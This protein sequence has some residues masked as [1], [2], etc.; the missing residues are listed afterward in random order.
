MYRNDGL[1][2]Q[3]GAS[4]LHSY[5][6]AERFADDPAAYATL[7]ETGRKNF[8]ANLEEIDAMLKGKD[9][10]MGSQYTVCDPYT[11]VFYGWGPPDQF[12]DEGTR[13]LHG[14]QGS[15]AAPPGRA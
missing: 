15:D 8:W 6:P 9:W 7:K 2:L 3:H 4:V 12:A 11:L 1:V 13:R 14:I 5:Q 10:M